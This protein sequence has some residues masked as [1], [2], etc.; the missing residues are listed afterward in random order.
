MILVVGESI[1]DVVERPD[2]TRKEHAGGS[3]ANVAAGLGRLGLDVTLATSIGDDSYGAL[4]RDHLA[5]CG[6]EVTGA[7]NHPGS[8]A[9]AVA[10]LDHD[11]AA[12]Y[13]FDISWDPGPI[14]VPDGITAVHSGSIAATVPPGADEV[15]SLIRRL[16][17]TALV[18]FDPNLRPAL[19]PDRTEV[20]ARVERFVALA[21]VVKVSDEDLAWLH[22]DE[23]A[24]AVVTRWLESGPAI[25]VLTRGGDG[26]MALTRS[27]RVDRPAEPTTVVDTVGAGDSYMAGLLAGLYREGLLDGDRRADLRSID[28]DTLGRVIADAAYSARWT[29]GRAGAL[30]PD[31]GRPPPR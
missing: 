20:V 28:V 23:T 9:S 13:D 15:E 16:A 1:V 11:G 19:V 17:S 29:V 5:A 21:D 12:T 26:S 31:T 30:M 7:S 3:P 18:S 10:R 22:P 14:A 8:T 27:G 25:V 24:D 4:M 6:V 2:G